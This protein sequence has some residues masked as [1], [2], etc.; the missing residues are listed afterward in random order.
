M[1]NTVELSYILSTRNKLPYL[2]K[3]MSELILN[4]KEDEE[5]VVIDGASTDGTNAFLKELYDKGK[6]HQLVSEPDKGESHGFNKGLLLAKGKL[7]K[8]ITDDDAFNHPLIQKC[9]T[10]MLNNPLIDIVAGNTGSVEMSNINSLYW[11]STFQDDFEKWKD[12]KLKNF[13]FNGTCLMIRKSSLNLTGLF[14]TQTLLADMEFT[15]RVTSIANIAWCT[16]IISTRILNPES[17]NVKFADKARAEDDKLCVFYDYKHAH[18]RRLEELEK[19]N[20]YRKIRSYLKG[21]KSSIINRLNTTK[22]ASVIDNNKFT[23]EE[24]HDHCI[25]W[26]VDNELNK[27]VS[28]LSR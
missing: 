1:Y 22:A 4:V 24:I 11:A 19:R 28:F 25:R 9:K 26:M 15:L 7:I 2:R 27:E 3:V 17:N 5:L 6:I 13:F 18:I 14:N 23:F 10:Y 20:A 16:G 8:V 12:G 21:V